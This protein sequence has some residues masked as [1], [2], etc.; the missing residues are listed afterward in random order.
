MNHNDERIKRALRRRP[1][2]LNP[3]RV[4]T[5]DS[6]MWPTGKVRRRPRPSTSVQTPQIHKRPPIIVSCGQ[7]QTS[8]DGWDINPEPLSQSGRVTR[9]MDRNDDGVI[10]SSNSDISIYSF[11]DCESESDDEDHERRTPPLKVKDE[12]DGKLTRLKVRDMVEDDDLSLQSFDESDF[13]R[14]NGND[15]SA[16]D[17]PGPSKEPLRKGASLKDP[18]LIIVAKPNIPVIVAPHAVEYLPYHHSPRLAPITNLS[19]NGRKLLQKMSGVAPQVRGNTESPCL[20]PITNTG[21]PRLAPITNLSENSRKLLQETAQKMAG[22][23][24]QVRGNTESPCLAPITNKGSP[25]LAP[26][27]NLSENSRK[28]LQETAQKMAGVYPQE[29]KVKRK[30]GKAKKRVKQEQASNMKQVENVGESK[31]DKKEEKKSLR[32]RFL[33]W[34]LPKLRCLNK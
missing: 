26:I 34:L 16:E 19:E 9:L 32:K 24:P 3:V 11:T 7:E 29:G 8:G 4:N 6:V 2:V 25:R 22:V 28:L 17:S 33:Q 5:P 12:E 13:L 21:S 30:K 18:R 15:A 31:E 1:Y 14:D 10:S 27:T 20:A 23:Y